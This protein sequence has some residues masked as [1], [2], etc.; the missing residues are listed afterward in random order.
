V[1]WYNQAQAVGLFEAAGFIDVRMTAAESD[2]PATP[3]DNS[4][5]IRGTRR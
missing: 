2:T 4:I 3:E 5:K 1:R